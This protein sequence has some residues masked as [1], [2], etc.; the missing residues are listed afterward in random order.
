[1]AKAKTIRFAVGSLDEPFSDIWRL[2]ISRNDV[3]IGWSKEAMGVFKISLHESGV[4]VLAATEQSGATFDNGNRRGKRWNRPL[5][6]AKGVTRGPSVKIPHTSLGHCRKG[7]LTERKKVQWVPT[8]APGELVEFSVYFL[9]GEARQLVGA[10]RERLVDSA[11]LA[12]GGEVALFA[13]VR[14]AKP[15]YLAACEK[16][17]RE[18]VLRVDDVRK[19]T[20]SSFLWISQSLG[21]LVFPVITELP[22]RVR[23]KLEISD[24]VRTALGLPNLTADDLAPSA[25]QLYPL[26]SESIAQRQRTSD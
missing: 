1:M 9:D 11:E 16:Y 6:H 15:D 13:D 22:Q 2:V 7:E 21:D 10:H 4:W 26:E 19:V 25:K 8:P 20:S 14:T 18:D 17:I 12:N 3:Y 23:P 24:A 5:E